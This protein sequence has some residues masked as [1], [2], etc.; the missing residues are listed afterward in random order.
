MATLARQRAVIRD[1]ER[2]VGASLHFG[3]GTGVCRGFADGQWTGGGG[4]GR[5]C[6]GCS[7]HPHT[8]GGGGGGVTV[9]RRRGGR[10]APPRHV[11]PT[12]CPSFRSPTPYPHH[13]TPV[14]W[15]HGAAVP[16]DCPSLV[17]WCEPCGHVPGFSGAP[18]VAIGDVL[19]RPYTAGG[20]GG[21]P[22]PPGPPPPLPMFE[23]DS[24]TFA[25]APSVPRGFTLQNPQ[26]I[27]RGP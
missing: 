25:L 26:P 22:T 20:G 27:S 21:T 17:G 9:Q 5:S 15:G 12:A 19:E 11:G 24:Q 18:W 14:T 1:L 16:R 4:G 3:G 6:S 10:A 7:T 13:I 23:A 8:C 2:A